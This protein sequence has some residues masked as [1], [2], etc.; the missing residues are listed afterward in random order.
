MSCIPRI[1]F[2]FSNG[3]KLEQLA[4][5]LW[6]SASRLVHLAAS[7]YHFLLLACC[8]VC[9]SHQISS[10]VPSQV[11]RKGLCV[12][13]CVTC[14]F[15]CVCVIFFFFSLTLSGMQDLSSLTLVPSGWTWAPALGAWNLNHWTAREVRK[16]VFFLNLF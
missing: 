9:P 8:K 16:L 15:V 14:F 5:V 2:L 1:V 4:Q 11:T 13:V 10:I 7:V 6:A 3:R 12:C